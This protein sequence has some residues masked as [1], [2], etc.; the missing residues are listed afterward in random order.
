[1]TRM[2]LALS[3]SASWKLTLFSQ[4][5]RWVRRLRLI[6]ACHNALGSRPGP[7][8][9]IH[10]MS[11]TAPRRQFGS[12]GWWCAVKP[13]Q[14]AIA[15]LAERRLTSHLHKGT[16]EWQR[17]EWQSFSTSDEIFS[18]GVKALNAFALFIGCEMGDCGKSQWWWSSSLSVSEMVTWTLMEMAYEKKL[19]SRE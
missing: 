17:L 13:W 8:R 18:R 16:V 19:T 12:A 2:F 9:D 5:P 14:W 7:R 11:A 15:I 3:A 10:V 4:A 6:V 1:M